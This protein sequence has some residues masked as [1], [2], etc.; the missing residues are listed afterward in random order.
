MTK[1]TITRTRTFKSE[2]A[3]IAF[4]PALRRDNPRDSYAVV[5]ATPD[6]NE[7]IV[8]RY[9]G[10]S[11]F[12]MPV[13]ETVEM[14][15]TFTK[16]EGDGIM[17]GSTT[18]DVLLDGRVVGMIECEWDVDYESRCSRTQVRKGT[19]AYTVTFSNG[20]PL[21]GCEFRFE[22]QNDH[23]RVLPRSRFAKKAKADY[24]HNEFSDVYPTARK[25]LAAAKRFCKAVL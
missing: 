23:G 9:V 16:P 4:L 2:S 6:A 1:A 15:V 8:T 12:S 11:S 5:P 7:W 13:Q 20:H 14:G 25:A 17:D 22:V 3:A 21:D 19:E 10:D 18:Q 24:A